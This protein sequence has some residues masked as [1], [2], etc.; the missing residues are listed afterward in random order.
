[1]T[2]HESPT[3]ELL[4]LTEDEDIADGDISFTAIEANKKRED[5]FSL[6]EFDE[7]T[8]KNEKVILTVTVSLLIFAILVFIIS[9][10]L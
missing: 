7:S 8:K 1:M 4:T 5:A 6:K 2:T 3:Q 9:T 10:N